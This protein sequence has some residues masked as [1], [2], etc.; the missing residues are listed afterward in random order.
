MVSTNIA[1]FSKAID[2]FVDQ[3]VPEQ[4]LLFQRR[5]AF[6]VLVPMV[7][8]TPVRTGRA[9]GAYIVSN[10]SPSSRTVPERKLRK[11][12]GRKSDA[13]SQA[14]ERRAIDEASKAIGQAVPFGVIW[15][16]NNVEYILF[17][18][19]GTAKIAPFA[20]AANALNEVRAK[21]GG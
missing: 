8:N 15:I 5:L 3:V 7:Q 16:S 17:L 6:D 1:D 13:E 18:E 12:Q 14:I 4:V 2:I 19:E 10:G 9:K 11:G 20:M 21:F